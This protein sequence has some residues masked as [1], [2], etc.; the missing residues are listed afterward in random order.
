MILPEVNV[1]NILYPTDLSDNARYAFAYAV[2]LANL[3]KAKITI[4]H[5]MPEDHDI[6]ESHVAGYIKTEKWEEIKATHYKQARNSLI[7]KKR[8]H[9]VIRE[10]LGQFSEDAKVEAGASQ[11]GA[12]DEI[13]IERG[14]PVEQ[15]LEQCKNRT[16]D[17]IVMGSRGHSTLA[18]VVMG[19]ITKRVLRRSEKPVLVVRLPDD[20]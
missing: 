11:G 6:F 2:S 3:Y 4:L 7:G 20:E 15:I 5:V 12:A 18:D 1:K 16:C 19:S 8:D 13:L 9:M 17:L 14:N 10:V